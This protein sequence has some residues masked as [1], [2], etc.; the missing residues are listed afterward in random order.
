MTQNV[1]ETKTI[2]GHVVVELDD[3][4]YRRGVQDGIGA[5]FDMIA[6]VAGRYALLALVPPVTVEFFD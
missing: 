2:T 5:A 3:A 4:E 1:P 6:D